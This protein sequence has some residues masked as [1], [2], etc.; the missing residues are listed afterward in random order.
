MQL[1]AEDITALDVDV[2]VW[3]IGTTEALDGILNQLPTR[4]SL[5]AYADGREI[6][7]DVELSGAFSHSS[8]LSLEFVLERMIPE[9]EAAA[10]GDPRRRSPPPWRSGRHDCLHSDGGDRRAST[11]EK[12]PWTPSSTP[13]T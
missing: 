4:Q 1:S 12:E 8:P 7:A 11:T 10:D 13:S 6:F 2:L 3:V 5:N 9:I